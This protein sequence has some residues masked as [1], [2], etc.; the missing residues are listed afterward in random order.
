MNQGASE[1]PVKR[2]LKCFGERL[3]APDPAS[4]ELLKA[5]TFL[6]PAKEE[7]HRKNKRNPGGGTLCIYAQDPFYVGMM[8]LLFTPKD[9]RVKH[10]KMKSLR[11]TSNGNCYKTSLYWVPGTILCLS[12]TLF[13][14]HDSLQDAYFHYSQFTG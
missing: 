6:E 7:A 5:E 14:P 10:H 12:R 3:P 2:V 4:L 9:R 8:C 1:E 13:N 11:I